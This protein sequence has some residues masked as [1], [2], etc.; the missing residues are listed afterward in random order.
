MHNYLFFFLRNLCI[1]ARLRIVFLV[2]KL[3]KL[4]QV[5]TRNSYGFIHCFVR[6]E[7]IKL[8]DDTFTRQ[9]HTTLLLTAEVEFSHT[10]HLVA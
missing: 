10:N 6:P 3:T 1:H 2:W 7:D 5:V 9:I 4:P 8:K